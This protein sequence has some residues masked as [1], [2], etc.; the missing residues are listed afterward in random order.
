MFSPRRP[1]LPWFCAILAAIAGWQ[2]LYCAMVAHGNLTAL[3]FIGDR[4]NWPAEIYRGAYVYRD[5]TGYDG[6]IYRIVA[7]DPLLRGPGN[8]LYSPRYWYRRIFVPAA[9]ALLG[10]GHPTAVDFGYVAVTDLLL[11]FGGLCFVRLASGP[12]PPLLAAAAYCAI[13][14]VVA[15][16]DRMVVDGPSLALSLAAWWFYRERR[17][18]AVMT[19]LA[20]AVLARETALCVVAGVALGY[21]LSRDRRR[22]VLSTLTA[23]PAAAWWIWLALHSPPS[24]MDGQLSTPLVPQI[25]RLFQINFRPAG[26]L[27]NAVLLPLD[28]VAC[29]CLLAAF[30]WIGVTVVRELR[31]G[32]LADDTVLVLPMAAATTLFSSPPLLSEP[33]HFLRHASV[34]IAWVALRGLRSR[35]L[36]GAA[37]TLAAG[38]PLLVYR[39]SALLR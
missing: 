14:A 1:A 3:F 4:Q 39:G 10:A 35:P 7:H 25:V 8:S 20:L 21:A 38:F 31:S 15:S 22:A 16:T 26:K 37:Y 33:Y 27:V 34:L 2:A 28:A 29:V 9:A 18:P 32:G 24:Q 19:T 30:A 36:Y 12:A 11:A 6:Q 13:P 23:A 5:S 17:F